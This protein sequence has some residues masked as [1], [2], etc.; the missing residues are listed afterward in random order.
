MLTDSIEIEIISR[1]RQKNVRDPNRSRKHFENIF[2]DFF[3]KLEFQGSTV[4]DLGPGQFDFC[5]I[6][7]ERGCAK[8][9]AV[10]NDPAVLEL[11]QYK[12]YEIQKGNLKDLSPGWFVQPVDGLFCKFSFNAFWFHQNIEKLSDYAAQLDSIVRAG[13]WAWLA[14]WN[15]VPKSAILTP[16]HIE[17]ILSTQIAAFERLGY[18]TVMLSNSQ[19]D[20]Y[21]VSG[22]VANSPLFIKNI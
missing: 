1:A 20:R 2:K 8:C 12:G 22:L 3:G 5:E 10:D 17:E 6:A 7:T 18:K 21:G 11:G 15:G 13:G 4:M 19:T 14:P 9:F 16:A